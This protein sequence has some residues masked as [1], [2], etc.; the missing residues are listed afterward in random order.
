MSVLGPRRTLHAALVSVFRSSPPIL[1][2]LGNSPQKI[3][4]ITDP[5]WTHN[6]WYRQVAAG[7][8]PEIILIPA[9][10]KE[11]WAWSSTDAAIEVDYAA[12]ITTD[13]QSY[14]ALPDIQ[15]AI[16]F[17]MASQ[18]VGMNIAWPPNMFGSIAVFKQD[19]GRYKPEYFNE[20]GLG[21]GSRRWTC[22]SC[23]SF[24][25]KL[26]RAYMA[27]QYAGTLVTPPG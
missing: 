6:D 25:M 3:I 7:N 2:Q 20:K 18:P 8:T 21:R 5:K 14:I 16:T 11:N 26:P 27:Q 13:T 17:T 23:M 9:T 15:D 24:D 1:A 19:G 4:D 12:W 22:I 10:G